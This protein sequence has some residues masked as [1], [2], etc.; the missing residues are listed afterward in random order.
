MI[1]S[2]RRARGRGHVEVLVVA[3]SYA[4]YTVLRVVVEGSEERARANANQILDAE[5][6]LGIDWERSAQQLV[7]DRQGWITFWN[8]IYQWTYWPVVG[9]ALWLL[10]RLDRSKYVLLRNALLISASM[11]LMIF[12]LY[13]VAPPRFLDG[14]VDTLAYRDQRMIGEQ[15]WAVNQYA[16]VPSFHV[17]WP[18]VAGVVI[19]SA[20]RRRAVRGAALLPACLLAFAVVFTGNHFVFDVLAGLVVVAASLHLAQRLPSAP[21]R[22]GRSGRMADSDVRRDGA[23]ESQPPTSPSTDFAPT[24]PS[25]G[26]EAPG[27]LARASP[28][29]W[30][31]REP[32][33]EQIVRGVPSPCW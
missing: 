16:A 23:P 28:A 13:P 29:T 12:A 10:W 25:C 33:S 19:A 22:S 7:L 27:P 26:T 17:G 14:Y 11:G 5:R 8:A 21:R 30:N 31:D 20:S 3:A 6:K 15:A 4:I 2:I 1:E 9:F 24:P 18:A 32:P